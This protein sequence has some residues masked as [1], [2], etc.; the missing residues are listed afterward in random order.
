MEY[1]LA[2]VTEADIGPLTEF[3]ARHPDY[4][5]E[6]LASTPASLAAKLRVAPRGWVARRGPEIVSSCTLT[7]KPLIWDGAPGVGAEIGD[8]YTGRDD[9]RRGLFSALVDRTTAAGF[10]GGYA[11]IYSTPNPVSRLGYLRRCGYVE[12]PRTVVSLAC[13]VGL[14]RSTA[15]LWRRLAR[16][17]DA[18]ED[19]E[20][21]RKHEA[22]WR[23]E[24]R[25]YGLAVDRGADYL[26]WRFGGGGFRI[27]TVAAGAAPA[28]LVLRT[29]RQADTVRAVIAD[30]WASHAGHR[31]RLFARAML[32]AVRA[33]AT[34]LTLWAPARSAVAAQALGLGFVPH[35]RVSVVYKSDLPPGRPAIYFMI[36]DSDNV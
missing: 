25:A 27:F 5:I 31:W 18:V 20:F 3:L 22:A 1:G 14:A 8:T 10:G 23:R 12:W 36:G 34:W 4:P 16:G 30:L 2:E 19:F 11:A 33:G 26:G 35:R 13:A 15:G 17:T 6:R 32:E 21:W 29:V 7:R 28:Y 24:A 9:Q